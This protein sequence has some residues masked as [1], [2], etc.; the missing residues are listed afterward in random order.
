MCISLLHSCRQVGFDSTL[1]VCVLISGS[2]VPKWSVLLCSI[3]IELVDVSY[4]VI[5]TCQPYRHD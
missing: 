4:H 5:H 1:S 2:S 3:G